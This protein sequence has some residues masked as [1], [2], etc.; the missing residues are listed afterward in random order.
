M[1]RYFLGFSVCVTTALFLSSCTK[2]NVEDE[3]PCS[4]VEIKYSTDIQPILDA[5][6][7]SCHNTSSPAAGLDFSTFSDSEKTAKDGSLLGSIEHQANYTPMPLN[8][9]K[10]NDCQIL[11]IITWINEG[12]NNN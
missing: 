9:P 6:C 10:L 1:N 3:F 12:S 8:S 2:T 11:T 7:V 4:Q 5:S